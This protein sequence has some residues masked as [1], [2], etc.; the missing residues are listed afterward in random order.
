MHLDLLAIYGAGLLTFVT[1]C[2]LPLVPIY[3]AALLGGAPA[4]A[5]AR[6]RLLTRAGL[7]AAGF[8][9]VFT[10]LGL[11]ASSL[12]GLLAA[13]RS[14]V[15]VIGAAVI[16]LFGLKFLGVLRVPWLDRVVRVDERRL[17]TRF[18][19]VN[20]VFMG[21]LFAAGWSPC[22]GPVLGSVLT[23]TASATSSPAAGAGYLAVYGLGLATPL[24]LTAAFAEAGGRFLKR[25]RRFVPA[26]ERV[27]GA[28]MVVLA[29]AAG[30]SGAIALSRGAAADGGGLAALNVGPGGARQPVVV[31]LYAHGCAACQAMQPI[32]DGFAR[33]C[34]EHQVL[35]K[36]VETSTPLGRLLG[37]RHHVLGVPT[38][39]VLD[40]DGRVVKQL[41]GVQTDTA[42][43]DAVS[44]LARTPCPAASLVAPPVEAVPPCAAT[45]ADAPGTCGAPGS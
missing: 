8:V 21:V 30:V 36:Q 2:V 44:G 33:Q 1:P 25:L 4:G 27:M 14:L 20:A 39:L 15:Q 12:G 23:Y 17:K 40:Q 13:H 16:L 31:E 32:I 26:L 19:A 29:L 9:A 43:K 41:V 38:F 37:E 3:L 11:T 45:P 10:L 42:L 18:G 5:G 34:A 28:A 24:L 7:F 6:G 22:V 35:V